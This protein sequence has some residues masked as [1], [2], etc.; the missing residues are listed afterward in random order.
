MS[1]MNEWA[2]IRI[3]KIANKGGQKTGQINWITFGKLLVFFTEKKL[4][5]VY[6]FLVNT[7]KSLF[8]KT[9]NKPIV[10]PVL[11]GNLFRKNLVFVDFYRKSYVLVLITKCVSKFPHKVL[12]GFDRIFIRKTLQ[13]VSV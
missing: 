4:P 13:L 11:F 12:I 9:N 8:Y 1:Y 6:L 7:K 5:K 10:W 2:V 3:G